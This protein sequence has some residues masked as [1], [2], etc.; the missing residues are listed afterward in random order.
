[1]PTFDYQAQDANG[2]S[3]RGLQEADSARHARQILRERGL[4]LTRLGEAG[5]GR[6]G[7]RQV[8]AG[9]RLGVT[10]LA[11]LT[12]QLS[13]LIHAGLPL[14]EALAAVM[15][16]SEKRVV[17]SLLAAVRS[18]VIEGHALV[19]A[20]SAFPG[21]FPNCSGPPSRRV[22][23]AVIWAMSWNSWRTTPKPVR[24][25]ARKSSW[26]WSTR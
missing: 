7:G 8:H 24:P 9:T 25:P 18:R 26:R 14:E 6:P 16:Q 22:S 23:A 2:R 11:L 17:S 1:M 13:T 15:A 10:D 3:C 5:A 19:T 12:R 21:H 4:R 20:L